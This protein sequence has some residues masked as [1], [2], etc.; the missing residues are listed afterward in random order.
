MFA[1]CFTPYHISANVLG[2]KS[3]KH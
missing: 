2:D 3:Q 1:K